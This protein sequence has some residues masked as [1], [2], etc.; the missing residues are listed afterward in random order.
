MS[1]SR[2]AQRAAAEPQTPVTSQTAQDPATK[3]ELAPVADERSTNET[4]IAAISPTNERTTTERELPRTDTTAVE[5]R[6]PERTTPATA[7]TE[8]IAAADPETEV[9][10]APVGNVNDSTSAISEDSTPVV[11]TEN[12]TP[13]VAESPEVVE[14]PAP[15]IEELESAFRALTTQPVEDAEIEPLI[16]EYERLRDS[17][18]DS[19]ENVAWRARV[20][21]RISLL[22]V[23]LQVQENLRDL[24]AATE[25]ADAGAKA[26]AERMSNL[27]LTRPYALV[28]RLAA[29]AIYDGKR[30]PLMYRLQSVDSGGGR[31]IAYV[32]PTPDIDLRGKLG[33]I[34]GVEG[35]SRVD[36]GL[37][38][39]IVQPSR[40]DLLTPRMTSV[41]DDAQ[42]E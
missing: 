6:T 13:L 22:K 1:C 33:S 42:P 9:G 25:Q 31:T 38:L 8:T 16:S 17:I 35:A 19:E 4:A 41:P 29:S 20:E 7:P 24:Q 11:V 30:L 36:Q 21:N 37:K 14:R 34:V 10:A 39:R 28:G 40:V 3:K 27:D 12:V 2:A 26:I 23:R 5:E 15:T 18:E 32:V